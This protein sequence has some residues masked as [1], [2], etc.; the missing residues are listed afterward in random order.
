[1]IRVL[2]KE[3]INSSLSC[4]VTDSVWVSSYMTNGHIMLCL[5]WYGADSRNRVEDMYDED[6]EEE[7][8]GRRDYTF[9]KLKGVTPEE[10]D[11]IVIDAFTTGLLDLSKRGCSFYSQ[12]A[13]LNMLQYTEI[14]N[15]YPLWQEGKT[16]I[17]DDLYAYRDYGKDRDGE[18]TIVEV[19][20]RDNLGY[21]A[22]GTIAF[23]GSKDKG[24]KTTLAEELG[25]I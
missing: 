7:F 25:K 21:N 11:Q 8:V 14:L 9:V 1:M 4:E 3:F 10:A 22:G 19:D 6:S 24:N 13:G 23:V 5:C 2:Y 16:D 18:D 20:R 15:K 12:D 17:L